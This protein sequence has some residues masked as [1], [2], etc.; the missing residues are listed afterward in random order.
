MN[1]DVTQKITLYRTMMKCNF[2]KKNLR[3]GYKWKDNIKTK[4]MEMSL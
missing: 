4:L 2:R 3:L 1:D